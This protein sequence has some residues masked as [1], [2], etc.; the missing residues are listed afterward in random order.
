MSCADES[1]GTNMNVGDFVSTYVMTKL[2]IYTIKDELGK[3]GYGAVYRVLLQGTTKEFALKAEKKLT[4][5]EHSK[6]N[7]EPWTRKQK[8]KVILRKY[9]KKRHRPPVFRLNTGYAAALQCLEAIEELHRIGFIHRDIKPGN[10][11]IGLGKLSSTVYILDF[12][13]AR[14][15]LNDKDEL[16]VPRIKVPFKGT[17]RFAP[18]ATHEGKEL[19]YKDDCES[20]IYL[21]TDMCNPRGVSWK[22]EREKDKVLQL[23][24]DARSPKGKQ[25]LFHSMSVEEFGRA[26]DYLSGLDYTD[27]VDY[28]FLYGLVKQAA[29]NQKLTLA[30][31]YDW[32]IMSTTET[33]EVPSSD[34][35]PGSSGEGKQHAASSSAT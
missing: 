5:R 30:A 25:D 21:V 23:K 13:I 15:I 4:H 11:S 7:M 17:V 28:N 19:S 16:K 9:L 8:G 35:M 27:K 2:G 3:G 1:D 10:Y 24:R 32:D 33:S 29:R 22:M 34:S 31:P 26:L 14:K 12:G 18:V 20:W 6:L